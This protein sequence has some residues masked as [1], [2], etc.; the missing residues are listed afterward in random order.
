MYILLCILCILFL[1]YVV[2]QYMFL[3]YIQ[4]I[5]NKVLRI[6]RERVY[7]TKVIRA[8]A[9]THAR[10]RNLQINVKR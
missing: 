2:L 3:G 1:L 9:Y 5:F 8:R 6:K 4:K 7:N 10:E